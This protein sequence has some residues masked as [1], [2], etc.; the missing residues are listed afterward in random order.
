MLPD[1][2]F[3]VMAMY[4]DELFFGDSGELARVL[5]QGNPVYLTLG[6]PGLI[7]EVTVAF[8]A[9]FQTRV[10]MG[11][12]IASDKPHHARF[13]EATLIGEAPDV[14]IA[15]PRLVGPVIYHYGM[16][17]L[18]WMFFH[19]LSPALHA[20]RAER[21]NVVNYT[22]ENGS[23]GYSGVLIKVFQKSRH[24]EKDAEWIEIYSFHCGNGYRF[25]EEWQADPHTRKVA[26]FTR[27][28][29]SGHQVTWRPDTH[30][31]PL[32]T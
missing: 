13:D 6:L 4:G 7:S 15:Y 25:A 9:P 16:E 24:E 29:K 2:D 12:G 20:E 27:I 19:M 14:S 26:R 10:Y 23:S 5:R 22:I 3:P 30:M 17:L 31:V 21:D 8:P 28:G 32:N 18:P 11:H 1:I